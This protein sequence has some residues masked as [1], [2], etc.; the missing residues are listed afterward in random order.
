MGE[1][2]WTTVPAMIVVIIIIIIGHATNFN[3]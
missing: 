2:D 3:R 1:I